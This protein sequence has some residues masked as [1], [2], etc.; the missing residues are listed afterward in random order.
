MTSLPIKEEFIVKKSMEYFNDPEPCF[1]HRGAVFTRILAELDEYFLC[2]S[3]EG[4]VEISWS[5][6]PEMFKAMLDLEPG[7]YGV[8]IR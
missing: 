4:D 3:K 8:H 6:F 2:I 7:V 1:I 5:S